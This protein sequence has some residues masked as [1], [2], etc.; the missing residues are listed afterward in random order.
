MK[1]RLDTVN[2]DQFPDLYNHMQ[3]R[4]RAAVFWDNFWLAVMVISAAVVGWLIM[5]V[6]SMAAIIAQIGGAG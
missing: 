2:R 6:G 1:F 3:R 4:N 5:Q